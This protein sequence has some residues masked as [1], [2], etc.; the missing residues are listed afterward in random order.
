[1]LIGTADEPVEFEWTARKGMSE[2][3]GILLKDFC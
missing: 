1:M 2:N 3:M